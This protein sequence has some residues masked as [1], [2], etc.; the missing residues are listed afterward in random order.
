MVSCTDSKPDII[1][2]ADSEAAEE[3]ARC[4]VEENQ[5]FDDDCQYN[6]DEFGLEFV[7]YLL[8]PWLAIQ[9]TVM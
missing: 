6:A 7:R 8:N 2:S 4:F 5:E 1:A 3:Y 9:I